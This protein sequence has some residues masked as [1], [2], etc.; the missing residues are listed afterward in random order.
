[1]PPRGGLKI[2]DMATIGDSPPSFDGS[3]EIYKEWRRR[4]ELWQM[5]TKLDPVKRGA[6]L[7]SVLTGAAWD[8]LRHVPM[9]ELASEE[10]SKLVFDTLDAIFADPSD[11]S[12]VEATDDAL[13]LTVRQ[14]QEELVAFQSRLDSKFRRLEAVGNVSLPDEVKGF[15]LAKQS[16]LTTAELREMLTLSGGSLKYEA[17]KTGMR[18]LMWDFSKPSSTRR[19]PGGNKGI[20]VAE[21]DA[22]TDELEC[23]DI[24]EEAIL[25]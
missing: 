21:G 10:G 24:N 22:G 14:A 6:K 4:A 19:A 20:F 7:V 5:S 18:R 11:V 2:A 13:Y 23:D 17:I 1:M 3:V 25:E 8:A 16:G 15:V 9:N 12:L